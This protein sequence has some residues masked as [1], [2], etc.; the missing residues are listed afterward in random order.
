MNN[1]IVFCMD[2]KFVNYTRY[3]IKQMSIFDTE[4]PKYILVD[5]TVGG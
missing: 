5:N 3:M 1:C 4:T 2:Q